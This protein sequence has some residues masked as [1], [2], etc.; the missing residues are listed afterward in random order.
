MMKIKDTGK[1]CAYKHNPIGLIR[2]WSSGIQAAFAVKQ[3]VIK[4]RC[5]LRRKQFLPKFHNAL[6]FRKEPMSTN[7]N[8]T[9]VV[10][11]CTGNAAD[12]IFFFKYN[13]VYVRFFQQFIRRHESSWS[14]ANDDRLRQGE[15]LLNECRM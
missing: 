6:V 1:T 7:I 4:G 11:H 8:I 14:G 15:N 2:I 12:K 9:V 13:G 5:S 10:V 3:T